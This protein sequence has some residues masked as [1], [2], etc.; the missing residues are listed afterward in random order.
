VIIADYSLWRVMDYAKRIDG[1][2]PDVEVAFA[3]DY[4]APGA[5]VRF[6]AA[7]LA[8]GQSVYLA[9]NQPRYAYDLD[10]IEKR[11]TVEPALPVFRVRER[12]AAP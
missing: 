12:S 1:V 10:G 4:W 8:K 11:Y 3:E 2:R 9:T 6:I 5:M 7:R